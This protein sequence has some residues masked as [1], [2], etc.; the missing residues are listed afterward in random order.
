MSFE[1]ELGLLDFNT[2][3][4]FWF[5]T[6]ELLVLQSNVKE[7]IDMMLDEKHESLREES[8]FYWKEI[9]YGTQ[10]FERKEAQVWTSS[11]LSFFAH[12]LN[13]SPLIS[14]DDNNNNNNTV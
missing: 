11:I 3:F 12:A 13:S 8:E 5:G 7:L 10:K 1:I 14:L 2:S 4:G 6:A 9:Y